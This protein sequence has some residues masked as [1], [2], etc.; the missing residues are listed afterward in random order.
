MFLQLPFLIARVSLVVSLLSAFTVFFILMHN[1]KS[2]P[3]SGKFHAYPFVLRSSAWGAKTL[4][5]LFGFD[6]RVKGREH[7]ERCLS[8]RHAPIIV[9]NHVSYL[10]SR[11]WIQ[12]YV[13]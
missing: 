9:M 2:P 1:P 5:W 12:K 3:L 8:E 10:V 11:V 4:L 7:V 6:V 13:T